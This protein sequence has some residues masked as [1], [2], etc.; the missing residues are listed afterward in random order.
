MRLADFLVPTSVSLDLRASSKDEV[1]VEMVGVLGV[2]ERSRERLIKMIGQREQASSTGI[3]R[4]IAIP[5]CRT[6][7][8]TRL[9][10]AFG[11]HHDGLDFAAADQRPVHGVFLIVAPPNEVSNQYLPVLAK[12]AQLAKEPDVLEKLQRLDSVDGFFA[13]LDQKGV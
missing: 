12:I 2:D 13:L 10:L 8:T 1:I 5:H 6:L 11:R 9:R 7:A 3:G 4:G